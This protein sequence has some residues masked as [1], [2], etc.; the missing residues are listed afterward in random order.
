M[1]C[2]IKT[3]EQRKDLDFF[4]YWTAGLLVLHGLERLRFTSFDSVFYLSLCRRGTMLFLRHFGPLFSV[5]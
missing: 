5:T 1:I 2:G 3:E 4:R